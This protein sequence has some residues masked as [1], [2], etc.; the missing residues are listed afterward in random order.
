MNSMN[1]VFEEDKKMNF[2]NPNLESKDFFVSRLLVE[3]GI[4]KDI[5]KADL[6]SAFAMLTLTVVSLFFVFR[7]SFFETDID[8]TPYADLTAREKANMPSEV[9]EITEKII[10]NNR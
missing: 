7:T 5:K 3:K 9:R 8:R 2:K 6:I 1:V 4:V 10:N